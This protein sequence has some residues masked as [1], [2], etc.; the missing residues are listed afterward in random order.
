[1]EFLQINNRKNFIIDEIPIINPNSRRY[2]TWWGEQKKRCIDGYWSIDDA[3]VSVDI[4]VR[5]PEFPEESDSWR[6]IPPACYFYVNFGTIMVNRKGMAGAK[7]KSRPNLDD[8]EWEFHYNLLEARGFSGFEFDEEYS[9]NRFL[10]DDSYDNEALRERCINQDG[11]VIEIMYNNFFKKNGER[12]TYVPVRQYIRKKFNKNMG[13]PVY[14]NIP[15]NMMI[16]ATRDG[17]KSYLSAGAIAHEL[18]FDGNRIFEKKPLVKSIAEIIVGAAISDKSRDLLNKTKMIVEELPG[19]WKPNTTGEVPAPFYKH[20]T[21]SIGANKEWIHEYDKKVG[22]DWKK[23]GS[24][25]YIKHRV[26]TTENVEAAAGGRPVTI[27]VEEVGLCANIISVHGSNDAAQNDGGEKF[28]TSLYIGTAGNVDKIQD[29]QIIFENPS[30]FDMLEFDNIWED[31]SNAKICWFIPATHM[32][33]RFKDENG[34]TQVK[35]ATV[36]FNKRR[37]DRAKAA[38][39]RALELEMMNYPLVPSEMFVNADANPFPVRDIKARY[40]QLM[41]SKRILNMSYKVEF[42]IKEDGT[43]D[44]RNVK[45]RPIRDFPVKNSEESDLS[46]C[47]EIF[48]MPKKLDDGTVPSNIYIAGYDPIDDDDNSDTSRSLQSFWIMNRLTGDLVFEY[49]GR[50]PLAA[51]FYEQCRRAMLFYNARCNYENNKKGFYNHMMNKASLYLLVPTPEVLLQKDMQ[52]STG[53]GN[54]SL[55]TNMNTDIKAFGIELIQAWLDEKVEGDEGSEKTRSYTIS[56]PALL[57]ELM[58][59]NVDG[60][61]DRIMALITVL[62]LREDKR[63]FVVKAQKKSKSVLDDPF[64]RRTWGNNN[65]GY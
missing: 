29:A 56:S 11:E 62:I 53:I 13:R 10:L 51:E 49:T 58:L 60:N 3:E 41:T 54:K 35:K 40:S 61:F 42:I 47:P 19:T 12:K 15:K 17:G 9:C 63:R 4:S 21:G 32:A 36:Y 52:K 20:M 57:R 24:K 23:F 7:I 59:F 50:T 45:K 16:L 2:D 30:G 18:I 33:R 38:S 28:G 31:D 8:V 65:P 6:Y 14:G 48:H 46:G 22:G 34:N 44:F 39:K 64:F 37:Q 25:S 1:M 26:F 43:V 5:D 55:G 27:V